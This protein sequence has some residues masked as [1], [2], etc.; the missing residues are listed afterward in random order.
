MSKPKCKGGLCLRNLQGFNIALLSKQ[1]WKLLHQPQSLVS[2]VYK[3]RYFE[4][5]TLIK[6]TKGRDSSFIWTGLYSAK[7]ALLKGFRWVIGDGTCVKAT[8]DPWLRKKGDFRVENSNF[9]EGRNESVSDLF[10]SGTK[11]WNSQL[12]RSTFLEEDAKAILAIPIPEE[13]LVIVLPGL[14]H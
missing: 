12:I 2:R 7:E 10:L 5:T 13:K 6:A 14:N 4:D 8:K 11:C 3:A 9:Y 1:C